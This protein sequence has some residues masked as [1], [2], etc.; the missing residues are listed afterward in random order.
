M[1][2]LLLADTHGTN[3]SY[4]LTERRL[5]EFQI[6]LILIAGDFSYFDKRYERLMALVKSSGI[7]FFFTSGNHESVGM[8]RYVAQ[9]YGG[10][11][12]DG[13]SARFGELCLVGLSGYDIFYPNRPN[14]VDDFQN[15][16]IDMRGTRYSILL[17]HEPPY[18]GR[19]CGSPLVSAAIEH[20][21]FDLVVTGHLHSKAPR[22]E[23]IECGTK[24]INPGTRGTVI[25]L[26]PNQGE[27][28]ILSPQ[29]M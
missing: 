8:C 11:Y 5:E 10:L 28:E 17:S 16:L 6:D 13:A 20:H 12:L 7:P 27:V 3:I 18:P 24:V 29:M 23:I 14:N 21:G 25:E 2:I 19:A 9:A 22:I 15:Q 1:Q 4:E 26:E